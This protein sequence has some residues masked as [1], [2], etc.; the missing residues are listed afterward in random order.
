MKFL[1]SLIFFSL[2]L[3]SMAW[4]GHHPPFCTDDYWQNCV[5]NGGSCWPCY[6]RIC[7]LSPCLHKDFY[8][9][10]EKE[11]AKQLSTII[12]DRSYPLAGPLF[13][14]DIVVKVPA[15]GI[16]IEG[17][18]AAVLYLFLG[19]PA[20]SDQYVVLS[21]E[22][23]QLIQELNVVFGE[24]DQY[25]QSVRSGVFFSP[26]ATWKFTFNDKNEISEWVVGIDS[27]A[28]QL[29]LA[30]QLDLNTTSLCS[31]IQSRCVDANQQYADLDECVTFMNSIPLVPTNPAN[32]FQGDTVTCRSFH[33]VLFLAPDPLAQAVH[34][35]HTGQVP[36]TPLSTPCFDWFGPAKKRSVP[37]LE[38]GTGE[39]LE[40]ALDWWC[41]NGEEA[42]HSHIPEDDKR[43]DD[44]TRYCFSMTEA[45]F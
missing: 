35:P 33:S 10:V 4:G 2:V 9:T 15:F 23:T 27:L 44:E 6:D 13:A 24:I 1:L 19:D 43:H 14:E 41:E 32:I 39:V 45:G 26:Y 22:Y 12:V 5:G 37:G 30:G 38:F 40:R 25:L 8:D 7:S 3:G 16:E 11:V 28:I 18:E 34:C 17:R 31:L 20:I 42:S 36:D 29:N 21:S